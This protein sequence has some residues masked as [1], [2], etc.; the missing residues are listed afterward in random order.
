MADHQQ[1]SE[2]RK[3]LVANLD[4]EQ[5]ALLAANLGVDYD[6]LA[7]GSEGA[8]ALHLIGYL[9]RRGRIEELIEAVDRIRA[10]PS[11]VAAGSTGLPERCP[12]CNAALL[13]DEVKWYNPSLVQCAYCGTAVKAGRS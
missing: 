4:R 5:A 3:W 9:R 13:P 12:A 6:G 8:K 2:L 11:L 10:D 1:L 7:G